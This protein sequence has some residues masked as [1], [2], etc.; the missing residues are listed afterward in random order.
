[1]ARY[2]LQISCTTFPKKDIYKKTSHLLLRTSSN[3]AL[4]IQWTL[5]ACLSTVDMST[6][7]RDPTT[8][9]EPIKPAFA[10]SQNDLQDIF[11]YSSSSFGQISIV[12]RTSR[13][14]GSHL[15]HIL[16]H[17][18]V[19]A[20]TWSS[21]QTS[22]TTHAEFNSALVYM[23]R[24]CS[25]TVEI[26]VYEPDATGVYPG[27][28][29]GEVR[30]VGSRDLQAGDEMAWFYPNTEWES[31][32]PFECLCGAEKGV[33]GK[34]CIGMQRGS[35]YLDQKILQPHF[36]NKHVAALVAERDHKQ[37]GD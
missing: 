7:I 25:P 33:D 17:Y 15:C 9:T 20:P 2:D 24:S 11:Q 27:G 34:N 6:S 16:T 1:M 5:P 30:V 4:Q 22:K 13:P 32:R 3:R 37:N 31:P 18:P 36:L 14:R 8:L 26:E 12:S 19:P 21:F 35:K 23:N 29:S 10:L 28:I